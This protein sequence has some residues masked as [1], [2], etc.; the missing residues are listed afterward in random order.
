LYKVYGSIQFPNSL[1]VPP[2]EA[3]AC[4]AFGEWTGSGTNNGGANM[5]QGGVGWAGYNLAQLPSAESNGYVLFVEDIYSSSPP[6]YV[7]PP[8]WMNGV[9]G[10]T[11]KETTWINALCSLQPEVDN[12]AESWTLGS[13]SITVTIGCIPYAQQTWGYSVL[14]TPTLPQCN[15]IGFDGVVCQAPHFA[16][17]NNGACSNCVSLT[18][19]LCDENGPGTCVNFNASGN[20]TKGWYIVHNVEDVQTGGIAGGGNQWYE[21]WLSPGN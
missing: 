9:T 17:T 16:N 14:E 11:I 2:T 8:T 20:P 15:G 19:N 5:V 18:G 12:W 21:T 1:S 10:Q 6:A 4:C 13:N 3:A 7:T